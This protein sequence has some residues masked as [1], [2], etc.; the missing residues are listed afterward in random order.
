MKFLADF[1]PVLLF[2]L[3]YQLYDIYVATAV[4]IAASFVQVAYQWL[5]RRSVEKMHVVTLGLLVV[6][7]GLTLLL[8]DPL[9]IKWKPT[10]VNWLFG[11]AFLGS[12]YVGNREPLVKRL[13]SHAI[14][15]PERVWIRLNHVW[16]VFFVGMGLINLFVAYSF[17]EPVWVQ[18][19]LFGIMGLTLLFVVAQSFY[20]ARHVPDDHSD[21]GSS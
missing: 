2:F 4:A 17:S 5:R 19:K 14:Q 12:R 8:R 11:I 21:G 20:M 15:L 13:M 1:F 18:F 6:F 3:A 10:I 9:F 16:V 7:G